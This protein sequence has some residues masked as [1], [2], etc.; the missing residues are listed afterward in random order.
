MFIHFF[1]LCPL[2]LTVK[3]NFNISKVV[4]FHVILLLNFISFYVMF[5]LVLIYISV[6]LTF[7]TQKYVIFLL[8]V[9]GHHTY[10]SLYLQCLV[11]PK[12]PDFLAFKHLQTV[13]QTSFGDR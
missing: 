10:D 4:Y 9:L 6:K 11:E 3:L 2:N 12:N 5:Y 7:I 8:A 13:L 1:C